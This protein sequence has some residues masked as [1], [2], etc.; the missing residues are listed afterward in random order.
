MSKIS[1]DAARSLATLL[2]KS[3][4]GNVRTFATALDGEADAAQ[5]AGEGEFDLEQPATATYQAATDVLA[6][7]IGSH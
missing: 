5:A 1:V 7:A 6:A 3:T 4:D 2:G